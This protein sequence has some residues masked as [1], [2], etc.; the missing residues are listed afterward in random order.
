MLGKMQFTAVVLMTLLT[1]KLLVLHKRNQ[2]TAVASAARWLMAGGTALMVLHFALQ[3]TMGLRLMGVTQS[4]MFNLAMLIPASYLFARAVL[5][6]QRRGELNFADRWTG[7]AVWTAAMVMLA[8]AAL[9]DG[10]PLL[11]DTP[12]LRLAERAG[13]VLYMLMLGYYAWRQ[14][15]SLVAMRRALHDYYDRDTD[16]MLRWMQYSI[17]GLMLPA[18]MVPVAIFA[19]TQWL[20]V[21][22][23]IAIFFFIFYLVDSFCY[24]LTSNG[25][26]I[27]AEAEQNAVEV[28]KEEHQEQDS[29]LA[30]ENMTDERCQQVEQAVAAWTARGGH[31]RG[32]ITQPVAANEIGIPQYQL[33]AW[34]R[35]QD[36][37]Y[38]RWLS[39]LRIEEA[40]R[41]LLEHPD[42]NV[43][44]VAEHCGFAGR[45]ILHRKF[46]ESTGLAPVEYQKSRLNPD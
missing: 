40:K 5:L 42:W 18:L 39:E 12:K 32:G 33:R 10:E 19:S 44:A 11:S 26:A 45:T 1:I 15:V 20:L 16:G 34:L 30:Q 35:R 3:L 4:V 29:D 36:S 27:V 31:L 17:V 14:S 46:K 25:Q 24:Y 13:A 9:T 21:L 6:L 41:V 7:P 38:N 22:I 23:A 28:E 8:V 2:E 43:D 37:T